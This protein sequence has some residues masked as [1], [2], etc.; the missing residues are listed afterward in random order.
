MYLIYIDT[1]TLYIYSVTKVIVGF[2]VIE[3]I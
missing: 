2:I 1:S 3:G